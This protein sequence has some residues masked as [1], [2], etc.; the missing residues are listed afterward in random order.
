M[1]TGEA[2]GAE[3]G[4][5]WLREAR[6]SRLGLEGIGGEWPDKAGMARYVQERSGEAG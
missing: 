5:A 6:H 4:E 2:G 3:I 1:Q